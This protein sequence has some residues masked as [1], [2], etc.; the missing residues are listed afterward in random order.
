MGLKKGKVTQTINMLLSQNRYYFFALLRIQF[1]GYILF[2]TLNTGCHSPGPLAI[3]SPAIITVKDRELIPEGIAVHPITGMIYLSSIH[4][5]KI[6]SLDNNG[7]FRDLISTS[8]DGFMKGLGIKISADGKTLWACCASL[9]TLKSVSGLFQIDLVSGR[10]LQKVFN[11]E[12]APSLYNDLAIHSS[13]D[14]Y[15]TDS[16]QNTVFRY[17]TATKRIERWLQSERLTY[18]NG[19]VF[20]QDEKV[21]FV[22]SGNKGVQRIDMATKQITSLTQGKRT[23]YAIDGLVYKERSLI[24]VIGWPHDQPET[25]RIIRYYLSDD[26][27]MKTVDTLAINKSYL[28]IPTTAALYKNQLY[29]LGNTNL[30]WYNKGRQSL[31]SVKDSLGFPTVIKIN[32]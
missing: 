12:D 13:G 21:L 19:I 10:V 1:F 15:V 18:A 20:S 11:E 8:Q 4:K 3:A 14:I 30:G 27:Y 22:A 17:N 5:Q 25:H 6:V 7:N 31:Q 16:Y 2:C 32:Y 29:V 9:D 26:Y 23:D 24:G 28:N